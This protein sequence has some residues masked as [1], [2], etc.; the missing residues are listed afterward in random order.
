MGYEGLDTDDERSRGRGRR[1][2]ER[3]TMRAENSPRDDLEGRIEPIV[4]LPRWTT[5]MDQDG[6]K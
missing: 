4:V 1:G 5:L 2:A 3:G 6:G